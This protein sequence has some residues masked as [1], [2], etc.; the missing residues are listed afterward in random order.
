MEPT[1]GIAEVGFLASKLYGGHYFFTSVTVCV[2]KF[3]VFDY[4]FSCGWVLL[5]LLTFFPATWV[6]AASRGG[7]I[8]LIDCCC[9]SSSS[10]TATW[11]SS[12]VF[13]LFRR[14]D[15]LRGRRLLVDDGSAFLDFAAG[16]LVVFPKNSKR[17]PRCCWRAAAACSSFSS[18]SLCRASSAALE[19]FRSAAFLALIAFSSPSILADTFRSAISWSIR[20]SSTSCS[21]RRNSVVVPHNHPLGRRSSS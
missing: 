14:R 9:S 7:F 4:S 5:L 11:L 2:P 8:D 1:I 18:N 15:R 16:D 12:A 13:F 3:F 21:R 20:S 19:A 10:S 17:R 6:V